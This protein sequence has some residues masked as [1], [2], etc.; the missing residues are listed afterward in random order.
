VLIADDDSYAEFTITNIPCLIIPF[1]ALAHWTPAPGIMPGGVR[2]SLNSSGI[3][4][5]L[6]ERAG[7]LALACLA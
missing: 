3:I 4:E 1:T 6:F 2:V 5:P 7:R